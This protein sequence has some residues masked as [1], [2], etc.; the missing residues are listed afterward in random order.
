MKHFPEQSEGWIAV[1]GGSVEYS[2]E[3]VLAAYDVGA[4]IAA[5]GM[6]IVTGATTGIP[7]AAIIGAKVAGGV[8]VGFLIYIG[9]NMVQKKIDP[10]LVASTILL[11]AGVL[12]QIVL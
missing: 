9:V 5:H 8:V 2:E 7:Y 1:L 10:Y 4:A 11:T 6:G 3:Q 12:L